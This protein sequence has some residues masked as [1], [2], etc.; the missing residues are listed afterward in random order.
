MNH[1][2][3]RCGCH[4][5]AVGAP[6]SPA[7]ERCETEYCPQHRCARPGCTLIAAYLRWRTDLTKRGH[8]INEPGYSEERLCIAHADEVRVYIGGRLEPIEGNGLDDA[9]PGA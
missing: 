7:R 5:V 8:N 4:V 9:D 1:T 2:T 6:H 3:A